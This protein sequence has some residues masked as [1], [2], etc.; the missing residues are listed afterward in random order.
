MDNKR[1]ERMPKQIHLQSRI[2]DFWK[3]SEFFGRQYKCDGGDH[4]YLRPRER[5]VSLRDVCLR[6]GRPVTILNFL[7]KRRTS[8]MYRVVIRQ[9]VQGGQ[10]QDRFQGRRGEKA[11]HPYLRPKERPI[12]SRDAHPSVGYRVIP[13]NILGK[14]SIHMENLVV[15]ALEEEADPKDQGL[16]LVNRHP[17]STLTPNT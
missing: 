11:D 17:R 10:G 3:V 13:R 8:T 7:L 4:H 9:R 12:Y 15:L 16:N 1:P 2:R 14:G 5:Q 6:E